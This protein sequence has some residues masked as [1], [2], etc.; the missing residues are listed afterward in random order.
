MRILVI[1]LAAGL[2]LSAIPQPVAAQYSDRERRTAEQLRQARRAEELARLRRQRLERELALA[3]RADRERAERLRRLAIRDRRYDDVDRDR[4]GR[5]VIIRDRDR[6]DD[7]DDNDRKRRRG[8]S[9]CRDGRG[10]PVHGRRWCYDKGWGLGNGRVVVL[11][12]RHDRPII[13]DGRR[14]PDR[15]RRGRD[16]VLERVGDI[17]RGRAY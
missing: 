15:D 10:H 11:D 9:F 8:P 13:W 14:I 12:R 3:R 7:D 6:Y 5:Y 2:G 17:M 16:G 1:A 4:Y